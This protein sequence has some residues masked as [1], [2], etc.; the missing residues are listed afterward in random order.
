MDNLA[1]A[2][3]ALIEIIAHE[4]IAPIGRARR[5]G[6]RRALADYR[7][8]VKRQVLV[9]V[10]DRDIEAGVVGQ[11][12]NVEGIFQGKL[13]GYSRHLHDGD[14][15]P[16]LP[17]LVKNVALSAAGD[18]VGFKCIAGRNRSIQG[19][20]GQQGQREAGRL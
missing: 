17:R 13:F 5:R 11:I 15:S 19:A 3:G 12:E 9:D 18:E 4:G 8:R 20:R 6:R 16:F 7:G 10:I 1:D 2:R 14:V